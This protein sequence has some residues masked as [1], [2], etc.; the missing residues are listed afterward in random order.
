MECRLVQTL[1]LPHHKVFIGEIVQTY[2]EQ[3]CFTDDAVDF[4]KVNPMLF[5]MTDTSYWTLGG[6]FAMAWRVGKSLEK[7]KK[8]PE[9]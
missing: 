5:T 9:T 6:R 3:A 1:D 8:S 7:R 4:A 2:C